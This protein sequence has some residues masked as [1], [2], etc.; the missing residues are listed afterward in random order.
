MQISEEK[1]YKDTE[2]K[3][4]NKKSASGALNINLGALT[5]NF[6]LFHHT[7]GPACKIAGIVK[8]D[9]YGLGLEPVA[10]RLWQEGC[11]TFFTATPD[12]AVSLRG[13]LP[14]AEIAVLNGYVHG[15]QDAYLSHALMPVLNSLDDI[16]RWAEGP[17]GP[18][19][20]HF[21]T[22]M[23]RLGLGAD[24]TDVLLQEPERIKS[25]PLKA[26]MSHFACADAPDNPM[27]AEQFR[28]FQRIGALFPNTPKSIAN[29]GGLFGNK[30]WHLDMARPGIAL[31]GGN[32]V[33]GRPNPV[34]PVVRLDVPVLQ[35]R[36][37]KKGESI[38]YGATHSFSEDTT[39]A[40]VSLGYADGFFRAHSNRAKLYWN[41]HACP[42]VGRV[43]MDLASVETGH[44]PCPGP[45]PGDMLEVI[46]PHQSVDD[47]AETAGTISYEILTSL[48]KRAARYYT[49]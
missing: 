15:A 21:D 31:Y 14:G 26:I 32:P 13:I 24:E 44:L 38:G 33:P 4:L 5:A 39:A 29:S 12:E 6:R 11:R 35:V 16:G 20:L 34:Q 9:A 19:L 30:A 22:G 27:N 36:N 46:G 48:G 45:R 18:A 49:Q 37:V 7:A 40:T 25:F 8:A 3:T 28:R 23:N 10:K 47:L 17:R 1:L 42:V 2:I 41:G 43:S